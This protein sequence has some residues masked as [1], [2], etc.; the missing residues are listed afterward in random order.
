M[1][2]SATF[3]LRREIPIE[4]GYDLVVAGGGPA[5]TAAAVCAG[6]LGARVL[7]VEATGCLGGMGTSGLVTAF[8]PMANGN[9]MLVGGFMR[10]VVETMYARGFMMPGINPDCWR[11]RYHAWSP[12]RVEGLKLLLDELVQAAGVE[13]RFFTRIIDADATPGEG[14]LHGVIL[15]N[16]EGYRYIRAR[17]FIDATGDA[18]IADL[19]GVRCH[20]AGRDTPR[21]MPATLPSLFTGIDWETL[22]DKKSDNEGWHTQQQ[23]YRKALDAGH[24]TQYDRLMPGLS[25][26]GHQIGYLNGGH[27]FNLNALRCRDLSDGVMLG[28]RLAQEY[29]EFFRRY[30]PG[31]AEMEH[32]TTASLIGIRESRRIVGEYELNLQDYLARRE[33]PDQIGVFNKHV[34][35]HPYDC[36][37]EEWCRFVEEK[38]KT[39][40]LEPGEWFGIPYGILV[41][42]G[43]RN[44]WVA[45][46][47]ASSDVQVH[48]S[49]RVQPAA[50]MMGQAA[51]TAAVQA[52]RTKQSACELDTE[53]LV[54]TLRKAD[55]HL[56]QSKLSAKMTRN[57]GESVHSLR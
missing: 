30:V 3:S 12:F 18:V 15:N 35:I 6:R 27:I 32:V 1:K 28:R 29:L 47:C 21:I 24:F 11:K 5:G 57:A 54:C 19:A 38:E 20:E 10:E 51:G 22:Y 8:D 52:L 9:E 14:I 13:V 40:R 36:T 44:L 48:G 50:S 16:V 56:P 46:R 2:T 7:L 45:G 43:W 39:M 49:I 37:D 23:A 41:P 55:A 34:D 4:E 42:Q 31:C 17:S 53:E 26:V 33:F 25:K